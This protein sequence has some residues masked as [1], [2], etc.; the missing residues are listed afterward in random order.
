MTTITQAA[1]SRGVSRQRLQALAQHGRIPGA[2]LVD[3]RWILPERWTVA[4][5]PKRARKPA[6]L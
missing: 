4:P 5:P 6:K 3:G 1:Q 2:E